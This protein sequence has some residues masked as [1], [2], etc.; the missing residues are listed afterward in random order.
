MKKTILSGFLA[1]IVML[2]ACILF[3]TALMY[4]FPNLMKQYDN[5]QLYRSMK[6][7]VS[8]L[9]S[10]HPLIVGMILAFIWDKTKSL[11]TTKKFLS[12]GVQF[13]LV[14]YIVILPGLFISYVT[15]PYSIA[16]VMT[17]A[18][19][20]LI[21]ALLAGLVYEKVNG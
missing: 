21:L 10:L 8:M 3:S 2:I 1:G 9:F 7:P 15:S 12:K 20:V 14:Y 13:A 17:W 6:D 5:I 19:N 4:F 11:F 16:I 18:V